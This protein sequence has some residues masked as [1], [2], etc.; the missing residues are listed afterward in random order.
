M[1]LI[2]QPETPSKHPTGAKEPEAPFGFTV[3]GSTVSLYFVCRFELT[4]FRV[5]SYNPPLAF[6]RH[7]Y[8]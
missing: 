5:R 1:L 8:I 6:K 7:I 3:D 4:S 2:G